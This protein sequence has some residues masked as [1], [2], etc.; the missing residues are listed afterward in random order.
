MEQRRG[1]EKKDMLIMA[2]V[3]TGGKPAFVFG[4]GVFTSPHFPYLTRPP[5]PFFLTTYRV[6]WL[7]GW[8]RVYRRIDLW[9]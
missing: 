7:V 8:G 3:M 9:R 6:S 4:R 2:M 5:P 1:D